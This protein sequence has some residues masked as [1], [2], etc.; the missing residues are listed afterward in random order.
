MDLQEFGT[1][2]NE[3]LAELYIFDFLSD[4][5]NETY[6]YYLKDI[7]ENGYYD[8]LAERLAANYPN[9]EFTD[10]YAAEIAVDKQLASFS[11]SKPFNWNWILGA[12]LVLSLGTNIYF[13]IAGKNNLSK[14][15]SKLWQKLTPQEQKIVEHIL[16]DKSNKEIASTLFVSHSTVKTHIN[17][18]YKKLEVSSREEVEAL[19][20][21]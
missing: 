14:R 17:N 4:K 11:A 16:E 19:F 7:T 18:L 2:C 21:R 10:Q 13:L 3:P 6:G 9:T 12:L 8:S 20:G 15:S 5:R 1:V